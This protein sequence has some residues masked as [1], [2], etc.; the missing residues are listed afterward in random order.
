MK[1]SKNT[2]YYSKSHRINKE[3]HYK[4]YF[5]ENKN[6]LCKTWQGIKQITLIKKTNSKQLNGLKI[7]NIIV[8]DRKSIATEFNEFFSSVAKEIDKKIPKSK[9]TYTD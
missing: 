5:Q 4:N 8:N 6:N 9:R 1:H 2:K 3:K 7:N